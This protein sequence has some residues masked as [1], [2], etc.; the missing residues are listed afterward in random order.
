MQQLRLV[1]VNEDGT[2]VVL[3]A[4]DGS[5]YSLPLNDDLRA[6]IR[7]TRDRSGAPVALTPREVQVLKAVDRGLLNKQIAFELG[8]AEITVKMHRSSAF[9]KLKATTVTDMIQKV[10]S[11]NIR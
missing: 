10:R 9:R 7:R 8:I 11:L 3:S 1:G 2:D 5:R 4:P 6:A